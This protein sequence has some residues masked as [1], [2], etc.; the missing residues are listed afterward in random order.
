MDGILGT[1]LVCKEDGAKTWGAIA[2]GAT[3]LLSHRALITDIA[4]GQGEWGTLSLIWFT[5]CL[6]CPFLQWDT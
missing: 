2:S 3:L 6:P 4:D 5:D 1:I